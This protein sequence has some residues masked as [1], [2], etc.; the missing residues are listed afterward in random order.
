MHGKLV[1]IAEWLARNER[2][3]YMNVYAVT[4]ADVMKRSLEGV[5]NTNDTSS[6]S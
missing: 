3:E 2:E 5:K 4:R 1:L 6:C